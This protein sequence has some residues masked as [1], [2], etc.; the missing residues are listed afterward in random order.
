MLSSLF[1]FLILAQC[2]F[3]ASFTA[4]VK[5]DTTYMAGREGSMTL[6]LTNSGPTDWFS[7]SIIGLP[8]SW[9]NL[10]TSSGLFR[11]ES[12]KST[13]VNIAVN[14]GKDAIP[15]TYEYFI[16]MKSTTTNELVEKRVLVTVRQ[17]TDVIISDFKLSCEK[18]ASEV[19]VSGSI[20]NIGTRDVPVTLTLTFEN[21]VRTMD[22]SE[23][24]ILTEETFSETF[25]LGDFNPS[26]YNVEGKLTSE[27]KV[28]YEDTKEFEIAKVDSIS[29]E[30]KS[31]V[32]PFGRFVSI[33]G[34]NDGNYQRDIEY[35]SKVAEAW[36][37]VYTGPEPMKG[38]QYIWTVNLSPGE[39]HEL[40]YSEIY[41]PTYIIILII[42]ILGI[43]IYRS[44]TAL[45]ITKE[46]VGK[47][48]VK[49]GHEMTVSIQVLN[50][51]R[52]MTNL[53]VKDVI[54]NGFT[55]VTKFETMKPTLRKVDG[56]TEIVWKI[57]DLKS[58][59]QRVLHYKMKSIKPF[60]GRKHL[61][62]ASL[63]AKF[64]DKTLVRHSNLVSIYSEGHEPSSLAVEI[65]K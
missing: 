44:Y 65:D 6:T 34:I 37:I 57:G 21:D 35:K 38:E 62:K 61:Q 52:N 20:Y 54:P 24:K 43:M 56:G 41:W 25:E 7:V 39:Q 49:Y 27:N 29:M 14:P 33:V 18:C 50:K 23:L 47:N 45:V 28:L 59:E 5:S 53:V 3:A 15:L 19:I 40:G 16:T 60:R 10:D 26:M 8:S 1:V 31:F 64:G 12:G 55:L 32:T 11:V 51:I 22:I 48:L 42:I 46:V 9:L 36:Y 2:V 4:D 17:V 58:H 13:T 63:A 30:E